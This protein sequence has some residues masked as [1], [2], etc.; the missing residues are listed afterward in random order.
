M[1][2]QLSHLYMIFILQSEVHNPLRE[3]V[4]SYRAYLEVVF[5]LLNLLISFSVTINNFGSIHPLKS[6]LA[7]AQTLSR[8]NLRPGIIRSTHRLIFH[9]TPMIRPD[10]SF[11]SATTVA[12]M[13]QISVTP[14]IVRDA[15]I[16][17][18]HFIRNTSPLSVISRVIGFNA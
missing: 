14:L 13:D 18:H 11:P 17:T 8:L 16:F 6:S 1:S 9:L 5:W 15:G 4:C 7:F 2:S 3:L 12:S 10:S